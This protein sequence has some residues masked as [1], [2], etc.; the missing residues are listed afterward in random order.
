MEATPVT[1]DQGAQAGRA[2][3]RLLLLLFAGNG[4]TW[5]TVGLLVGHSL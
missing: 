2:P 5:F 1:Y 4:V 3:L